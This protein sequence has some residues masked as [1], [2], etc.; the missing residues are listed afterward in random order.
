MN[1]KI[2][3]SRDQ[4][5]LVERYSRR[6]VCAEIAIFGETW[7]NKEAIFLQLGNSF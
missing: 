1:D 7:I 5:V 2:V 3:K 4:S 6:K